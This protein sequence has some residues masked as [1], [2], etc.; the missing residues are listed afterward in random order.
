MKKEILVDVAK[1]MTAPELPKGG[2]GFQYAGGVIL[3]KAILDG[4]DS[5]LLTYIPARIMK[6]E[7]ARDLIFES[8]DRDYFSMLRT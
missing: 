1:V 7:E 4:S 8:Q 3:P 5:V 2:S 6:D